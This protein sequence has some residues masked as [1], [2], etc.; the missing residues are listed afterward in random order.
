MQEY[1]QRKFLNYT[2]DVPREE[3]FVHTDR[4]EYIAG[5][6]LWFSLYLI[7]RNSSFPTGS[8][9][10]Y[11]ELINSDSRPVA[12]KIVY[13]ND[14]NGNG[15]VSLPDTLS[16]GIY[17]LK[18]YTNWMKN[19]FP[20]NYF[21]KRISIYNISGRKSSG[22]EVIPIK[23]MKADESSDLSPVSIQI[24]RYEQT[25]GLHI[26]TNDSFRE[27]NDSLYVFIQTH[28]KINHVSA[29]KLTSGNMLVNIPVTELIPGINQITI[30]D[31]K[32]KP[33]TEYYIF[34]PD[35]TKG[36]VTIRS[37]DNYRRRQK[38]LLEI[39]SGKGFRKMSISVAP[40]GEKN[41][42]SFINAYM[43]SGTEFG[44]E[45]FQYADNPDAKLVD[46][47]LQNVKSSWIDW[48]QIYKTDRPDFRYNIERDW[49]YL[50]G[51]LLQSGSD[52][53]VL[54]ARV[55]MC[56]PGKEAV[57]QYAWTDTS[58]RF[59]FNLEI[60][61]ISRDLVL[62]PEEIVPGQK[63]IIDSPFS[64]EF[65]SLQKSI[66]H[67]TESAELSTRLF[68]YQVNRSYKVSPLGEMVVPVPDHPQAGRFY[69]KPD[70]KLNMS[71]YITL[72]TMGEVF[73]EILPDVTLRKKRSD[74]EIQIIDR[75][76]YT[77]NVLTPVLLLDGVVIND[78]A[79]IADLDPGIVS[80]IDVVKDNYYV[81]RYHFPGLVNVI[82]K[83]ADFRVVPLPA[84]MIRF[85]YR[86]IDPGFTF[87]SPDYSSTED[88]HF[89]DFR[90]TLYWNP[91]VTIE[92]KEAVKLEFWT[93]DV[94]GTYEVIINGIDID[95][96]PFSANKLIKVE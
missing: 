82:T 30:F 2:H 66:S 59:S 54:S 32:G 17:T 56:S 67:E 94:P 87:I 39:Q 9:I 86:V 78:P 42:G 79:L 83:T 5:E 34:S 20:D 25:I 85:P 68:N 60:D 27:E 44:P 64:D 47:L 26:T 41:A 50:C 49:H 92:N 53:S 12:R 73:Y 10:A 11:F 65:T 61:G 23:K 28:G 80:E 57:F 3:I 91:S 84:H 63:I 6:I 4:D 37:E 24:S 72:P 46:S 74:Y 95:G 51:R 14:S 7:E 35:T 70:I 81:G 77:R 89:P 18:A 22:N 62:M 8:K 90:N 45:L 1:L 38:V 96:N 21:M 52:T 40:P 29:E 76:S 75:I 16:S 33:C 31:S 93:G 88:A 58:G 19:F 48:N 15:Q 71:D 55:L 43:L 13:L 69:G 36:S